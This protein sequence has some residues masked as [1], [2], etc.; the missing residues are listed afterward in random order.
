MNYTGVRYVIN[1]EDYKKFDTSLATN[2]MST[3]NCINKTGANKQDE[4]LQGKIKQYNT[5]YLIHDCFL[6]VTATCNT[7]FRTSKGRKLKTRRTVHG[8]TMN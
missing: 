4:E 5:E 6:C 8:G 2:F 1:Q 7:A 3:F